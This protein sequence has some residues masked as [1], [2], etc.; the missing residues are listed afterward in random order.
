MKFTVE[1]IVSATAG[2]IIERKWKTFDGVSTDS[3]KI[4]AHQ[5][6]IPLRG[7]S[8]DGHDFIESAL[9]AGAR[10]FLFQEGRM[11]K[12]K[13]KEIAEKYG[14]SAI[15]VDDTLYA[16][17]ELARWSRMR[18]RH[19]PLSTITGSA[20][21]STT[22]EM[23][24]N[25]LSQRGNVL[26]NEGNLNN[27][28]GLPLTLLN[29]SDDVIAAVVELGTNE[30]GEIKR[31]AEISIPDVAC[32]TNVGPV[33]LEGLGSIEGVAE[34][35]SAL[36]YSLDESAVFIANVDN[37]YTAEMARKTRA[38][39][40]AYGLSSKPTFT[41]ELFVSAENLRTDL[42]GSSFILKVG[43]KCI[44]VKLGVPGVH[45]VSNALAGAAIAFVM[46]AREEEIAKGLMEYKPLKWRAQIHNLQNEVTVIEDC[47]NSNPLGALAALEM[48]SQAS[49]RKIAVLG[50]MLEL[51]ESSAREH[52][53]LGE[54]SALKGVDILIA[55]GSFANEMIR[56]FKEKKSEDGEVVIASTPRE[57]GEKLVGLLRKGDT[58]L[59]KASRGVHLEEVLPIVKEG[60]CVGE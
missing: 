19:I 18:F 49:S 2:R 20:G 10:G 29:L 60:L 48:L 22:K 31:L 25:I 1:Q 58:V 36:P 46:R 11:S 4:F 7:S 45:N 38:R 50:D 41:H 16:L 39:V 26:K 34:E 47:Y 21:K 32:V 43:D 14:A 27:L 33:H 23:T 9:K 56:G 12:E 5:L 55:V 3:R 8:F 59:V 42:L 37:A 6:F 44:E 13:G 24:A 15:E 35:K 17:G 51:G 53:K 28:I 30:P 40:V 54:E 57:A 52:Y